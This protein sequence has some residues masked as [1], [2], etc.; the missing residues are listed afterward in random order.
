MKLGVAGSRMIFFILAPKFNYSPACQGA[1]RWN[2]GRR[3]GYKGEMRGSLH[4]ALRA[5][6]EMTLLWGCRYKGKCGGLSTPLRSGRDDASVVGAG[7]KANAGVSP[8][9]ALRSGRDDASVGGVKERAS[10]YEWGHAG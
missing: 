1:S 7:T 10:R 4:C 3:C 9:R 2:V 6:V 5:P 8:L